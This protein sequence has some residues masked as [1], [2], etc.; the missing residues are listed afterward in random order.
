M[1]NDLILKPYVQRREWGPVKRTIAALLLVMLAAFYGLLCSVLPLGLIMVPAVPI[2]VMTV[3]CLWLLPDIGVVATERMGAAL[4][5]YF[6]WWPAWPVYVALDLPGLPWITPTRVVT[7]VMTGYAALFIAT[8]AW[9]RTEVWNRLQT[10]PALNRLFWG[11]WVATTVALAFSRAPSDSI[12]RYL[13]NQIFWTLMFVLSVWFATRPGFVER[14]SR[15]MIIGLIIVGIL[16]VN[17][18]R[19]HEVVWLPYLP[20]FLQVD[21]EFLARVAKS[22]ARA[23]TDIYRVRSTFAVALYLAEYLAMLTPL[24]LAFV[25]RATGWRRLALLAAFVAHIYVCNATD[26]RSAILGLLLTAAVYPFFV[27]WRARV[28]NPTSLLA[29]AGVFS[30]PASMVVLAALV[31]FWRRLHVMVLGGG[32]HQ[33]SSDARD[34]QWAMGWPKIISHPLGH[35]TATSGEVLGFANGAGQLTVDTYYLTCLLDY[36]FLGFACFFAMFALALWYAARVYINATSAEHDLALPLGV[37]LFIFLVIKSVAS[38][39]INFPLA[40]CMLGCIVGLTW[41]QR[42][43]DADLPVPERPAF[44]TQRYRPQPA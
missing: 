44:T 8:S 43:G 30:Y 3:L 28:R 25:L 39:E 1:A 38:T 27:V 41:R 18:A 22:Q 7:A 29:T 35:G 21:P 26:A 6:M 10:L 31:L 4:V 5:G 15:W 13:N 32:Q 14:V 16:G 9:F 12:N 17:E 34:T 19:V 24:L 2:M 23:G 33:A 42:H 40:F 20:S 36:G 11:F 37:G